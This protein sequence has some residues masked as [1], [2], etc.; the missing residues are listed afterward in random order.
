MATCTCPSS[1]WSRFHV[2]PCLLIVER[3]SLRCKTTQCW[4]HA[5]SSGFTGLSGGL[6][7]DWSMV[8]PLPS[9]ILYVMVLWAHRNVG[10]RRLK[11]VGGVHWLATFEPRTAKVMIQ[12][13]DFDSASFRPLSHYQDVSWLLQ[14]LHR[15]NKIIIHTERHGSLQMRMMAPTEENILQNS[16]F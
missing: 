14:E 6:K 16:L 8:P 4:W 15:D 2:K 12:L 1:H 9:S 7:I 5:G 13:T 3:C 10:Q 11:A